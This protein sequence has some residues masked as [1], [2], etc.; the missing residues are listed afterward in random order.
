[1]KKTEREK[2]EYKERYHNSNY[3]RRRIRNCE[4]TWLTSLSFHFNGTT[5]TAWSLKTIF[6]TTQ[7]T[8]AQIC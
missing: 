8:I 1:M 7:C 3:F 6:Q 5:K 4:R 2:K